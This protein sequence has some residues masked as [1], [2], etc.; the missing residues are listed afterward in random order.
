MAT[1]DQDLTRALALQRQGRVG[2]SLKLC[3]DLARRAPG[4][5]RPL[6]LAGH[7]L[8]A[9]DQPESAS[10][11]FAAA[12]ARKPEAPR[13][14]AELGAALL[15]SGRADEALPHLERACQALPNDA[16]ILAHLALA[17]RALRELDQALPHL[18]R[19]AALAPDQP[20]LHA[21]L[22]STLESLGRNRDAA[23]SARRALELDPTQSLARL[24]LAQLAREEGAHERAKVELDELLARRLPPQ[25]QAWALLERAKVHDRLDLRQ[26]AMADLEQ[27]QSLAS[28]LPATR[29]VDREHF[30]ALLGRLDAWYGTALATPSAPPTPQDATPTPAF[31]LGFPR[32][33]TTL[34]QQIV[35]AHPGVVAIDEQELLVQ[36]LL[37]APRL[38]GR[39]LAYPAMLD[40]LAD[41]EWDILRRDYWR[42]AREQLGLEL[43]GVTPLVLDKMPLYIAHVGFIQRLFPQA[44]LLVMLRDPRDCVLSGFMQ[45]FVP[46]VAMVHFDSLESSAS[47]YARVMGLW[48]QARK[49]PGLYFLELRY[50]D[51][52]GDLETQARRAIDFL[53]LPW[54]DAV[55]SYRKRLPGRYVSTPSRQDV[56]R[57]VFTRARGRWRRYA[58]WLEPVQPRLAPYVASFGYEP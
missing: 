42:R 23:A 25:E 50:E 56:A 49:L 33:G 5:A 24:V 29:R 53:G 55:L 34:T 47:L 19:A 31:L 11:A 17:L 12:L 28:G 22:A 40:D 36:T 37:A 54:D 14:Q 43:G 48:L 57:P 4:D 27:G 18:E 3:M 35:S 45:S 8:F 15:A 58:A 21:N 2:D 44:P 32:S 9:S 39:A 16:K 6:R 10:K 52:V 46:T 1:I 26:Q 7:L 20:D 38:V 13:L 51:V 30:P 41:T